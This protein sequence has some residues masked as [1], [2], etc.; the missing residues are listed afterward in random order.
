MASP[1]GATFLHCSQLVLE[2][3]IGTLFATCSM[4]KISIYLLA[5]QAVAALFIDRAYERIMGV[6]Q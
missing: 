2:T 5:F 1:L 3:S 6:V 4:V